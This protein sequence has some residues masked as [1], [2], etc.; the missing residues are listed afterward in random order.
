MFLLLIL[1]AGHNGMIF[2]QVQVAQNIQIQ[3]IA[4]TPVSWSEKA[5]PSLIYVL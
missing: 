4:G 2:G 3:R 5:V 1:P